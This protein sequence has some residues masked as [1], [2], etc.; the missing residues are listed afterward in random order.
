MALCFYK[1]ERD[2]NVEYP[3]IAFSI[4]ASPPCTDDFLDIGTVLFENLDD[5]NP[6]IRI[7]FP[8]GVDGVE[9]VCEEVR[10]LTNNTTWK[11]LVRRFE[12]I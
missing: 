1:L 4:H 10:D 3:M 9:A 2:Y 7:G 12:E 5:G 6:I 8:L 11:K